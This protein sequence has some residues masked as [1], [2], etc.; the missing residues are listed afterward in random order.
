MNVYVESNFILELAL[1]QEEHAECRELLDLALDKSRVKLCL[2]AFCVGE[3]YEAWSRKTNE[4]RDL[5]DRLDKLVRELARSKPYQNVSGDSQALTSL[6]L[7]SI[8]EQKKN[9]DLSLHYVL[10]RAEIIPIDY[11]VISRAVPLQKS[12]N[13]SP[14]DSIVFASVIS[15]LDQDSTKPSCFIT[16]NSR[17]F[18]NLEV[19]EDLAKYQCKLLTS[20]SNGIGY[21][22][23]QLASST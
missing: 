18:A 17:D 3:P 7:K 10:D 14:Q 6:L 20:F 8:E 21:I 13:L 5:K 22:Q 1:H 23:S 4:R 11:Q 16:K 15:H 9:L 2:P 12:H 19:K